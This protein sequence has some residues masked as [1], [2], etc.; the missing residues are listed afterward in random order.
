[1]IRAIVFTFIL[2]PFVVG[3]QKKIDLKSKFFGTYSG[4][5][6]SFQLDSG[7]DL[8]DVDSTKIDVIITD[9]NVII[10]VGKNELKGTY[11]VMFEA[12]KYFLLDCRIENQLAGER[13]VVY[14]KGKK[15]SRDG[16]YPQ[17]NS[18]LYKMKD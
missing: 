16:L 11:Y 13:I 3:A 2:L 14:K 10:K 15:I 9:S 17:P 1:M 8:V 7:K 12:K 5:I 6:S 4:L 18:F